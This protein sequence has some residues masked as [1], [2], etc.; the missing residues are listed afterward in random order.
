MN[1]KFCNYYLNHSDSQ[2]SFTVHLHFHGI[3]DDDSRTWYQTETQKKT[4]V[5]V[6]KANAENEILVAKVG[7]QEA[8][9][10][11]IEQVSQHLLALHTIVII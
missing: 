3:M 2:I 5:T 11:A 1:L 6:S 9:K 4:V 10:L 7:K 8:L